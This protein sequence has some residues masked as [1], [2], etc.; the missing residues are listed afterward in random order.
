MNGLEKENH[1]FPQDL[2]ICGVSPSRAWFSW[3]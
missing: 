2:H 1:F 3:L